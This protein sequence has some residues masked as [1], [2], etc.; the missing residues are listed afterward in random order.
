[1]SSMHRLPA[2]L[3]AA[4]LL[5]VAGAAQAAE[6]RTA[7]PDRDA[8]VLAQSARQ[9][10]KMTPSQGA[11]PEADEAP[12]QPVARPAPQPS[13]LRDLLAIG[14]QDL[15]VEG[16]ASAQ[17]KVGGGYDGGG[18][19]PPPPPSGD[20]TQRFLRFLENGMRQAYGKSYA[21]GWK[22]LNTHVQN[23]LRTDTSRLPPG[24]VFALRTGK[25]SSHG[26]DWGSAWEALHT[27]VKTLVERPG[28]FL[29]GPEGVF[30]GT[31]ALG[32]Q[33]AAD[34][35]Y[36]SGYKV[37]RT[38]AEGLRDHPEFCP[39]ELHQRSVRAAIQATAGQQW[40]H[41]WSS[42]ANGLARIRKG[43]PNLGHYFAAAVA[44][45]DD[46]TYEA[47]YKVLRAYVD[48]ARSMNQYFPNELT[49]LTAG[50]M[51]E[52]AA[53][54]DWESAW[55][56]MAEGCNRLQDAMS[57]PRDFFQLALKS[58]GDKTYE[59]GY[60]VLRAYADAAKTSPV[61]D[62]YAKMHLRSTIDAAAGKSWSEAW[63][64]MRDGFRQARDM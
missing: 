26:Q 64:V 23:A 36:E 24:L 11:S 21:D 35:T 45:D 50:T 52:A 28:P 61:F 60:K 3:V 38:F 48:G 2:L 59:G 9:A 56:I 29:G 13:K 34:K 51:I 27:T 47:G 1:M 37:L 20:P 25:A 32:R 49:R 30:S 55:E 22:I 57:S 31:L 46:M 17:V 40:K 7:F 19:R 43:V 63:E 33:A 42:L 6:D 18:N 41:A 8:R 53:G 12:E 14:G 10:S 15:R 39:D 54:Q 62:E 4:S 16:G 58:A 44:A 5:A